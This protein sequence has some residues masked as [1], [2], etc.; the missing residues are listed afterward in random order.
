MRSVKSG[1]HQFQA[2]FYV[3]TTKSWINSNIITITV[4]KG[5]ANMDCAFPHLPA[6]FSPG[7]SVV[8]NM[9]V[10]PT[11]GNGP[12]DW[13]NGSFTITFKGPAQFT[14]PNLKA[15]ASEQVTMNAPQTPGQY[16]VICAFNG[17]PK[18]NGGSS[19][20]IAAMVSA[21]HQTGAIQLYTNPT[22]VRPNQST[23]F[24]VVIPA[25]NGLPTPTGS[26]DIIIG[27]YSTRS[28]ALNS[29][30]TALVQL[31]TPPVA[32]GRITILYFGDGVYASESPTFPFTNPP[33]QGAGGG[34]NPTPGPTGTP[35]PTA[36]AGATASPTPLNSATATTATGTTSSSQAGGNT[37]APS[38]STPNGLLMGFVVLLVVAAVAG[39]AVLLLR[40][41][42]V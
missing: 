11:S 17:S 38:S 13:Q 1:S 12:V 4:G 7:Q 2:Q 29:S 6:I 21:Q 22:T 26:F 10:S 19:Y 35:K 37:T 16:Q 39:G 27:S 41:R 8:I 34:T 36:T 14:Y 42:V 32:Y 25:A 20:S 3:S 18:Y 15:N 30:G 23:T 28:I 40:R 9:N 33:I 24:Y 5:Y 31:V